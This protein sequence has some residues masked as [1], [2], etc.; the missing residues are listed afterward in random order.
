MF[1]Y[2][3]LCNCCTSKIIPSNYY[4]FLTVPSACSVAFPTSPIA[5]S[6]FCRPKRVPPRVEPH[7]SGHAARRIPGDLRRC[8]RRL[9]RQPSVLLAGVRQLRRGRDASRL[10]FGG[11]VGVVGGSQLSSQ[12]IFSAS[13]LGQNASRLRAP[14]DDLW[15]RTNDNSKIA[16]IPVMYRYLAFRSF[17]FKPPL[18]LYSGRR[19]AGG[20]RTC[21]M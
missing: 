13:G 14:T 9:G 1:L 5:F 15:S 21:V 6:W 18:G 11:R 2:F 10:F 12:R 16:N 8:G 17:F 4:V 19:A 3:I 20:P 7:R